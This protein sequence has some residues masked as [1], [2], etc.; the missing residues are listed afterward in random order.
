M[1]KEEILDRFL[2][3]YPW[4]YN[5]KENA[6]K[7]MQEYSDQQIAELKEK[8]AKAEADKHELLS[9]LND[10]NDYFFCEKPLEEGEYYD[11]INKTQKLIDKC[12]IKQ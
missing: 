5:S 7:A 6:I 4:M 9:M 10:L 3:G 11:L 1:T 12:S 8:L 2:S